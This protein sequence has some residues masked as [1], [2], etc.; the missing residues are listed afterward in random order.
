MTPPAVIAE[1]V[2]RRLSWRRTHE[3][4]AGLC[5]KPGDER[6]GDERKSRESHGGNANTVPSPELIIE[7]MT[8][9]LRPRAWLVAALL[10]GATGSASGQPLPGI[11]VIVTPAQMYLAPD[12]TRV[13]LATLPSG[14][15]LRVLSR[16]GDWYRVIYRDRYLGDRTGYVH[17]VNVRIEAAAPPG[18][19]PAPP[20]PGQVAPLTP[21][22]QAPAPTP[23][24][25]DPDR[26][27]RGYVWLTGGVQSESTAFTA[28]STFTQY[29]GT[30]TITTNYDGGRATVADIVIGQRVRECVQSQRGCDAG[31][32]G[33]RCDGH[34]ERPFSGSARQP[35]NRFRPRIRDPPQRNSRSIWTP[36]SQCR[37]TAGCKSSSSPGRH[38]FA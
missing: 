7:S 23:P 32:T 31:V 34:G 8:L 15:A 17:A 25:P 2:R 28:A 18:A 29:G 33:H 9:A 30:G 5:G 37:H 26:P 11:G 38:C 21:T 27:D 10:L 20:V 3:L 24:P 14:T 12:A 4:F 13:P 35:S 22:Q 6:N 36:Q 1:A 19:A 16:E